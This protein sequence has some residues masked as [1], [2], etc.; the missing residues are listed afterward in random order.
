MNY[1][2]RIMS[3]F[4]DRVRCPGARVHACRFTVRPR[5]L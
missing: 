4:A 5:P 1:E 2:L 3:A